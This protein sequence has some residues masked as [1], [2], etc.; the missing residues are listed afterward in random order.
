MHFYKYFDKL[1]DKVRYRLSKR[2]LLYGLISGLGL[3]L[4]W[5]GIDLVCNQL[6]FMT[7][8]VSLIVG[9]ILSLATGVLVYF[10][11]GDQII[12]SGLKQDKKVTEKAVT[13]IKT[14]EELITELHEHLAEI[15]RQLKEIRGRLKINKQSADILNGP[16]NNLN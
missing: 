6:G 10:F 1:E 14:E 3:I 12:I 11:V 8:V 2:P 5:R 7:G 15:D 9:G 16:G 13:E 4:F